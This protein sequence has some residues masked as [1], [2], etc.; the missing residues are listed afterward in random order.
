[1]SHIPCLLLVDDHREVT[2]LLRSALETSGHDLRIVEVP[3]GEEALLEMTRR[4]VDLLVVD[5]RLPGINGVEL[6]EKARARQPQIQCIIISAVQDAAARQAMRKVNPVAIFDKPVPLGDFINTVERALGLESIILPEEEEGEENQRQSLADL[7]SQLRQAAGAHCVYLISERGRVVARAGDLPDAGIEVSLLA[8]LMAI[9]SASLKVSRLLRS[10]PSFQSH[11]FQSEK[12]DLVFL[13]VDTAHA[14]LLAGSGLAAEERL[15]RTLRYAQDTCE[16]IEQAL[17][18]IG[19]A[20]LPEVKE[21]EEPL[22]AT[23]G[24]PTQNLEELLRQMSG[25]KPQF[26]PDSFWEE[27][28]EKHRNLPVNPDV[29]SYEQARRLG[30]APDDE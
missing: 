30:L 22:P 24:V 14:L 27:A 23:S 10:V 11:A 9:Y 20:P 17:K 8:A 2:R 26:D 1:M 16:E 7:L 21:T 18:A 15:G 13:P 5:Y 28:A 19:A 3:S 29:I 6:I 4:K 12:F 25:K